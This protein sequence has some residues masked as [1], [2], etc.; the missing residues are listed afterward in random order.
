MDE[1]SMYMMMIINKF[2]C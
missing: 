2:S 1:F